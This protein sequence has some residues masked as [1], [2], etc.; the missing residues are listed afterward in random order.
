MSGNL[1]VD[2][3]KNVLSV[4]EKGYDSSGTA[5]NEAFMEILGMCDAVLKSLGYNGRYW[6]IKYRR[7]FEV[8]SGKDVTVLSWVLEVLDCTVNGLRSDSSYRKG[9][10]F[11]CIIGICK[12][13]FTTL[14]YIYPEDIA[15]KE[16][17]EV[18]SGDKNTDCLKYVQDMSK[19]KLGKMI[20]MLFEEKNYQGVILHLKDGSMETVYS[21]CKKYSDALE[22]YYHALNNIK[23]YDVYAIKGFGQKV[24]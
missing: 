13:I 12:T 4:A 7:F 17:K 5:R 18:S 9:E 20:Y 15:E 19:T 8:I 22:E 14:E 3:V 16:Q 1:V 6:L 11:K 21:S 24:E 10:Y 23:T 2:W